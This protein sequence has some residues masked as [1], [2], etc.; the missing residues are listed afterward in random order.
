MADGQQSLQGL[1]NTIEARTVQ[2]PA[3]AMA[4]DQ[5]LLVEAQLMGMAGCASADVELVAWKEIWGKGC[6]IRS[7]MRVG[8]VLWA[9]RVF[10]RLAQLT[11]WPQRTCRGSCSASSRSASSS[12]RHLCSKRTELSQLAMQTA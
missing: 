5:K 8:C 1:M 6:S 10:H 4:P 7:A 2:S 9:C 3:F 11:C 12:D